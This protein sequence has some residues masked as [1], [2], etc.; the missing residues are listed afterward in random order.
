M[1][2]FLEC[3]PYREAQLG[4]VDEEC[5]HVLPPGGPEEEAEEEE[6]VRMSF[7]RES[8]YNS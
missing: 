5:A 8:S 3:P 4:G 2:Q 1:P 7:S 6:E